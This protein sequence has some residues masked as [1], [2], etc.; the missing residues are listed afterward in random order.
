MNLRR[1][2]VSTTLTSSTAACS[3]K[4]YVGPPGKALSRLRGSVCCNHPWPFHDCCRERPKSD[5]R[6][7]HP[8]WSSFARSAR[9]PSASCGSYVQSAFFTRLRCVC[10]ACVLTTS[11]YRP[12]GATAR[13][14]SRSSSPTNGSLPNSS[15]SSRARYQRHPLH[16]GTFCFGN[17]TV[18]DSAPAQA[19]IMLR[20]RPHKNIVQLMG[21]CLH[22]VCEQLAFLI[23]HPRG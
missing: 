13:W 10:C 11:H 23:V 5:G 18:T 17:F 20:L 14:W 19:N 21:V 12:S 16:S 3:S 1:R 8:S 7:S 2:S 4:R 15:R 6:S 22:P 9:A